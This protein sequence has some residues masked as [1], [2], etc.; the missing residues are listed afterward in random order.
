MH[1][2]L[3]GPH[4]PTT[5][6]MDRRRTTKID[7]HG[8]LCQHQRHQCLLQFTIKAK[9]QQASLPLSPSSCKSMPVIQKLKQSWSQTT[10]PQVYHPIPS[11]RNLSGS[12]HAYRHLAADDISHWQRQA[13]CIG[14]STPPEEDPAWESAKAGFKLETR[15]KWGVKKAARKLAWGEQSRR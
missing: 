4:Q 7:L 11:Y 15:S 1:T 8:A 9:S 2:G 5:D 12:R 14:S 6:P 10:R 13:P 3:W